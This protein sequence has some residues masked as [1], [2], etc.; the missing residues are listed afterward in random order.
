MSSTTQTRGLRRLL[1]AGGLTAIAAAALLSPDW[2]SV[3]KAQGYYGDVDLRIEVTPPLQVSPGDDLELFIGVQNNGPDTA[4]RVRVAAGAQRLTFVASAGCSNAGYPNCDLAATLDAGQRAEYGL[5]MH[6]G[7]DVRNHV[8]FAAS[9]ASD[10]SE[11][12][13]GDEIVV[14]K[15]PVVTTIDLRSDI[16][17]ERR[18]LFADRV[19][20]CSIRFLNPG[21]HSS[22]LPRLQARVTSAAT[23]VS[24]SCEASRPDL[25]TGPSPGALEWVQTPGYFAPGDQITF[26]ADI[27]LSGAVPVVVIEADATANPQMGETDLAPGNNRSGLSFEPSLFVDGFEPATD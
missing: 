15:I 6:V 19:A 10:D 4:H 27:R 22:R 21:V 26:R 5:L 7:D 24:W 14:F 2:S 18:S 17:C 1:F 12:A 9:V 8:Q 11:I 23:P 20:H 16:A 3:L 25:C 13:P